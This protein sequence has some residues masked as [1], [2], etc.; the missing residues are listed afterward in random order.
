MAKKKG[1]KNGKFEFKGFKNL[2]F[3]DTELSQFELYLSTTS[4]D[5]DDAIVT[6]VE[7]GYKLG[8]SYDDYH[9]TYAAALT[10]KDVGSSYYGWI[11]TLKNSSPTR[12]AMAFRWFYD[13]YLKDE[14]Y[15]LEEPVSKYEW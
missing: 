3:T 4:E 5:L 10:C 6:L 7:C 9:G 13:A 8:Y 15:S 11:F 14:L 2:A 1:S 12:L